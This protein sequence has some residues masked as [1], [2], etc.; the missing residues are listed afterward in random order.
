MVVA[1]TYIGVLSG[2]LSLDG[3]GSEALASVVERLMW[4]TRRMRAMAHGLS[5]PSLLPVI[6][7]F[8]HLCLIFLYGSRFS[9]YSITPIVI[10]YTCLL[11]ELCFR[12]YRQSWV[13]F[14][15]PALTVIGALNP[16]LET[17][18]VK[19][20]QADV[21]MALVSLSCLALY[22]CLQTVRCV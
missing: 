22:A 1:A 15:Y 13:F 2:G 6:L 12:I 21:A 17:Y 9:F 10:S 20:N 8:L 19:A 11:L 18:R 4:S 5:F 7:S 16:T 14:W 3:R